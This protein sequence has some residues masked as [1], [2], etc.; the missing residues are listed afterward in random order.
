MGVSIEAGNLGFCCEAIE[1]DQRVV[2]LRLR[3]AETT[4]TRVHFHPAASSSPALGLTTGNTPTT[5]PT[6]RCSAR[7]HSAMIAD[8]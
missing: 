6:S 3:F 4:G 1:E 8:R 7:R 2:L 5:R